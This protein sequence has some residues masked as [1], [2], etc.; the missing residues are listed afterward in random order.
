MKELQVGEYIG[1]PEGDRLFT[2]ASAYRMTLSQIIEWPEKAHQLA[3][4]ASNKRSRGLFNAVERVN[5]I[6]SCQMN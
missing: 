3:A 5:S 6:H 4:Q 2:L 1:T